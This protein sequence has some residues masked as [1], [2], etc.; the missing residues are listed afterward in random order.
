MSNLEDLI[1]R[2]GDFIKRYRCI[3][4][5]EINFILGKYTSEFGFEKHIF[6]YEN[7][8][9]I[10][11]LLEKCNTWDIVKKNSG[12]KNEKKYNIID[13]MILKCEN[14][15]YDVIITAQTINKS[16]IDTNTDN[17]ILKF[18]QNFYKRKNHTFNISKI[19]STLNET[20]YCT[21]IIADIPERYND[22]YIAHSSLLKIQDLINVCNHKEENLIFSPI[23]I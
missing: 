17:D 23:N 12:I 5:V 10:L 20:I 22:T 18:E 13:S 14:G 21:N 2:I 7:Y 3:K 15:P 9:K 1:T 6:Q 4:S 16:N 8:V 19:Q 11:N